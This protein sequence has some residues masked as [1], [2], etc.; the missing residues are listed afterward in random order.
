[1]QNRIE[2]HLDYETTIRDDLMH[3]PIRSKYPYY[4]SLTEAILRML[5]LKQQEKEQ[6]LDYVKWFKQT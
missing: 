6:L 5:Q 3:D 2:E 1:M 4:A